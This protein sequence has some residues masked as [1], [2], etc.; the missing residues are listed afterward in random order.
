MLLLV[1][2]DNR[3]WQ[4]S[5]IPVPHSCNANTTMCVSHGRVYLCIS[6]YSAHTVTCGLNGTVTLPE[7]EKAEP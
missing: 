7:S 6:D 4:W 3:P 1:G 5:G 2:C